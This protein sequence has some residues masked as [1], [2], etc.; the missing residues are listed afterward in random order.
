MRL[1]KFG[2]YEA[3]DFT[4]ARLSRDSERALVRSFMTHHQG[5]SFLAFSYLL[6]DQPMQRRFAADPLFQAALLLLQERIPKPTASYLQIP[7]SPNSNA[8]AHRPEASMRAFNTPNTRTPQVQLLSNGCYH[9]V[10]TQAGGGYSRWN[11]IAVT[12]WREDSTCDDWGLFS[13]VRDVAT[14]EFWSTVYQPTLGIAEN[15]KAVFTEAHAEFSR[16]DGWL[17][18]HTEVVVSPEDDIELRRI[19]IHNRARHRRII[20]FTSYS[21]IVLTSQAADLAQPAFSNLFVETELL[22]EQHAILATRRPL[23][24]QQVSPWLCHLLNVYSE[25]ALYIVL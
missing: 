2:F 5:M 1:G 14:G 3:I 4:P 19:R 20:E 10:L 13:Y 8:A 11:D 25:Q 7:K 9:T 6:H 21:E 17:D 22:P 24:A 12:R 23:D 18:L 16:N 15:F